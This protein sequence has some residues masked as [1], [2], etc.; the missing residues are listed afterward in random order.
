MSCEDE[1]KRCVLT[2][3][4]RRR[5]SRDMILELKT[6]IGKEVVYGGRSSLNEHQIRKLGT[7]CKI[8]F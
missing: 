7:K 8:N 4:D 2:I 5:S 1:L 3:L 6:V